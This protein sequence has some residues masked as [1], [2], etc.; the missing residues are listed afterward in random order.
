MSTL[1]TKQTQKI[2]ARIGVLLI[3]ILI[4]IGLFWGRFFEKNYPSLISY[5]PYVAGLILVL[6]LLVSFK[7]I[8]NL[9]KKHL[10]TFLC[11][12]LFVGVCSYSLFYFNLISL[13][14]EIMHT[15]KYVCLAFFIYHSLNDNRILNCFVFS[16]FV[17]SFIGCLEECSQLYVPDRIF[18]TKD[19]LL[20]IASCGLGSIIALPLHHEN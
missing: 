6:L 15:I 18:D 2:L 19:L 16:F 17:S 12:S 10:L 9:E 11:K 7:A 1:M 13:K 8:D 20:N 4:L 3:L 14:I 5:I